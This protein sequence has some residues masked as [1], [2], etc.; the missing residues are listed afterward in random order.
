ME[1]TMKVTT[2]GENEATSQDAQVEDTTD[3]TTVTSTETEGTDTADDSDST[4][5][6]IEGGETKTPNWE[7]SYKELQG[8]FTKQSQELA[9]LK[10]QI[11]PKNEQRIIDDSGNV[12]PELKHKI[13][14]EL[15]N[16]EFLAYDTLARRLAPEARQEVEHL[17]KEAKAVYHTKDKNAYS[18]IMTKVEDYFSSDIVKA[19]A[20]DKYA[21]ESQISSQIEK[22][23]QEHRN[24]RAI[25]VATEVAKS[26]DLYALT[27]AE[28]ENYSPAVR[29]IIKQVF[30]L[31]GG[32]D[33][34]LVTNA[35]SSIKALG[36]KEYL[37]KQKMEAEKNNAAV[38]SGA[39]TPQGGAQLTREYI[40]ANY[41]K[42]AK[43]Y[44]MEKIDKIIMKGN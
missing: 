18:Q 12:T 28:S 1:E 3:T 13:T 11:A 4:A 32:L 35:V 41:E 42:A 17:L 6:E 44:G 27:C 2:S 31:T 29:N 22:L 7:N 37:A 5:T 9:E 34:E 16:Q 40:L 25:E 24:S 36:V 20:L 10:K 33:T 14:L 38:P 21:K 30:D 19:I 39:N 8:A 23:K 43:K 26:E 15:D